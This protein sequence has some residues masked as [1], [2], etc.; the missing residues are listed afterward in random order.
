MTQVVSRRAGYRPYRPATAH[1]DISK[2]PMK[3][4][5]EIEAA[6]CEGITL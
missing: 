5:G 6:I 3:T 2:V 4:Q 1:W